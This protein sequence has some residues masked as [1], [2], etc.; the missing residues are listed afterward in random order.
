M[1]IT[2]QLPMARRR[3]ARALFD[4]GPRGSNSMGPTERGNFRK[5]YF[6]PVVIPTVEHIPWVER[7]IPIPPGIYDEVL[8]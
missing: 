8:G 5:D 6:E 7:N 4:Q 3:E 2:H 1:D